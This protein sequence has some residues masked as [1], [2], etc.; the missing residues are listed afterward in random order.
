MRPYVVAPM[1]WKV[2]GGGES[3]DSLSRLSGCIRKEMVC[4]P[5]FGGGDAA[6]LMDVVV[7]VPGN[8]GQGGRTAC[9]EVEERKLLAGPAN[10]V[11][12]GMRGG[13]QING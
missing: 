11:Q 3:G 2:K 13:W 5:L 9:C 1:R 6:G 8:S 10:Q 4:G 7:V 12:R